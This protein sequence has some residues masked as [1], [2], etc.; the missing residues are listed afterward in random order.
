[1]TETMWD[2]ELLRVA[3]VRELGLLDTPREERFD[4]IT[5]LTRQLLDVPIALVSLVDLDRQWFKSCAGIDMQE[6]PRSE[7][8]CSRAIASGGLL[9]VADATK[10]PRFAGNSLVLGPPYIRFYAGQ[11]LSGPGGHLV[12]TLCVID[13]EPRILTKAQR[14]RLRDLS[15]WVELECSVAQADRAARTAEKTRAD[16]VSVVG[17]ELHTP[18]TSIHGALELAGSGQFGALPPGV[19]KLVSIAAKNTDRLV[20]LADDVLDCSRLQNHRCNLRFTDVDLCEVVEQ[21]LNAVEGAA[22]RTG[23]QLRA[24]L[25]RCFVRGDLDRLVQ[26]LV[27][28]LGNAIRVAPNGSPVAVRCTRVGDDAVI[29]VR[30]QGPGVPQAEVERIFEPFVQLPGHAGGAGLGLAIARGIVQAHGGAVRAES[31]P[32]RGSTFTVTLP[33][34]GPDVDRPWW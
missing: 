8:L 11:P 14:H 33:V 6:G 2:Q 29:D 24:D 7:S 30:D 22:E 15:A 25:E 1:V 5:R 17:R 10:D 13:L 20:R 3:A 28:L 12:G 26:V 16:F 32:E 18:L 19:E 4:R 9:E 23:I 31:A 21:A 27:N 34:A